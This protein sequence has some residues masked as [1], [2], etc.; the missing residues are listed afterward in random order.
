MVVKVF[1]R[2]NNPMKGNYFGG[3]N[4]SLQARVA[5]REEGLLAKFRASECL[6]SLIFVHRSHSNF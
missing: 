1:R 6:Y 2:I 4:C 3:I 5:V